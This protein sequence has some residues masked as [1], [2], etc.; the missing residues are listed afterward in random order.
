MGQM[1]DWAKELLVEGATTA[2]LIV[3]LWFLFRTFIEK[4]LATAVKLESAKVLANFQNEI[5]KTAQR[6]VTVTEAGINARAAYDAATTPTKVA[7]L[8]RIWSCVLEWQ[9]ASALVNIV[10]AMGENYIQRYGDDD[11]TKQFF[12]KMLDSMSYLKLMETTG[13]AVLSRP[14]VRET[15]WAPFYAFHMLHVNTVTKAAMA[16]VQGSGAVELW[17]GGGAAAGGATGGA[18]GVAP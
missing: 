12:K 4:R 3:I 2:A 1:I 5:D 6:L 15:T 14:F 18:A 10:R 13:Q 17:G 7:A 8:E 9:K 16:M 11:R